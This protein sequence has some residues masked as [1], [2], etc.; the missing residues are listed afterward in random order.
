MT[1]IIPFSERITCT[2][3]EACQASGLGR[4]KLYEAV[5]DK[6]LASTKIDNRRLI[7]VKSLLEMLNPERLDDAA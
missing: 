1:H 7:L 3:D 4:T 2:V 6:R 5:A